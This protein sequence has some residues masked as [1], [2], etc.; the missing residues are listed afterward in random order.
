MVG[1]KDYVGVAEGVKKQLEFG[2]KAAVYFE[3]EFA[4]RNEEMECLGGY[5]AVEE[6]WVVIGYEECE[7]GFVVEYVFIHFIGFATADVGRVGDYS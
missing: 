5:G 3:E 7:V 4:A 6:E 2:G 1:A